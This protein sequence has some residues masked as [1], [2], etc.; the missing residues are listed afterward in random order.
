MKFIICKLYVTNHVRFNDREPPQYT[1]KLILSCI[2]C[3]LNV[4]RLMI[5]IGD[6]NKNVHVQMK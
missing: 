2:Y 1:R 4:K 5:I 3:P 6:S